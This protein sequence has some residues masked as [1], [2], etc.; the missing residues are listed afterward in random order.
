V[1]RA[2]VQ[3]WLRDRAGVRVGPHTADYAAR[4][5]AAKVGGFYVIGADARTGRPARVKIPAE[6]LT[7][8]D[9]LGCNGRHLTSDL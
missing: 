7:N 2:T 4:Q 1:D 5:L 9:P 6:L 3:Q 8:V